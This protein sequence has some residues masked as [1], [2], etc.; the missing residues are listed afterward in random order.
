MSLIAWYPLNGNTEDYSG[1]NYHGTIL[2]SL[3]SSDGKIGPAYIFTNSDNGVSIPNNN[4]NYLRDFT[5]TAWINPVGN[6]QNYDG[7]I[8]SSGNW[9]S[10]H[11]S[12]GVKQDNSGF[13]CRNPYISS[14][15]AP[16]N[17]TLNKWHFV[18]YK[19]QNNKL[20]L[21]ANNTLVYSGTNDGYIPLVSDATNTTI[22]RETYGSGYFS[23]NG[24]IQDVRI[25]NHALTEKEIKELSK[26]KILH[27][28]FDDFQEPTDNIIYFQNP[29]IDNSYTPFVYTT[30]GTWPANHPDAITVYNID[31]TNISSYV[32]TGVTDWTNANHATWVFDSELQRPVVIMR[33]KSGTWQAKFM[34]LSSMSSLGLS[35][36][37]Q[38]VISWLQWTSDISKSANVGVY[39]P[40]TSGTYGFYDG[41]SNSQTTSYNT[42]PYTWQRVYAIFTVNSVRNMNAGSTLYMYGHFGP[43]GTLKI[44][45]VQFEKKNHVTPF[46]SKVRGGVIHDYSGLKHH[47]NLSLSTTPQWT[48]DSKIGAG[49]Y[50][51]QNS[52][53]TSSTNNHSTY[54][55]TYSFW[56]KINKPY[57]GNFHKIIEKTLV[58]SDR[59]PGVWLYP[60]STGLHLR[61]HLLDGTNAGPGDITDMEVGKWYHIVFSC[62]WDGTTTTLSR[63]V[64][65]QNYT[66]NTYSVAP[67]IGNAPLSV[68]ADSFSDYYLDDLRIYGTVLSEEEVLELY[69]QRMN[70]D[71]QGN[72]YTTQLKDYYSKYKDGIKP[73]SYNFH[74]YAKNYPTDSTS[75][76]AGVYLN[77]SLVYGY[78]RDWHISVWDPSIGDWASSINFYG[79]SSVSGSHARY[80]IYESTTR[81]AQQNAFVNTLLNLDPNYIV[82]IAGSHAPEYYSQEMKSV[83]L[84][85][86]A[87]DKLLSWTTRESYILI[88]KKNVGEGN[89]IK[90][91]LSNLDPADNNGYK[92]SVAYFSLSKEIT[93]FE[94]KKILVSSNFSE[95][96]I[97]DG[98]IAY[99]P[100]D[101]HV[102]D[103]SGSGN[104]GNLIGAS[105]TAGIKNQGLAFLS[106]GQ[107]VTISNISNNVLTLSCWHKWENNSTTWRTLFG[108]NSNIHHVIFEAN[109]QLSLW[110]GSQKVYGYTV[111]DSN[112][113][114]YVVII[115]SAANAILYVDGV[116]IGQTSTSLDLFTYPIQ[117]IG[118]WGGDSYPCGYMDEVRVYNRALTPQEIK[119]MYDIYKPNGPVF[120]ITKNNIYVRNEIK[121]GL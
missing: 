60:T 67:L 95:A 23:F 93:K 104:H 43:R 52:S 62:D 27:Y 48:S 50:L 110:D 103:Y 90:E 77:S 20:F 78:S 98:L 13:S 65:G 113:H 97:A 16:H 70:L 99:Y 19:R 58:N 118:N 96:G 2:G 45:D 9:N 116:Y 68:I 105:Y 28:S 4:F 84:N 24:K 112:W 54:T 26:A 8:I 36:G 64:N 120:K 38:Y 56:I 101:S 35:A 41:L 12:F 109:G 39:G 22:G 25:Y 72:L 57:D 115:T 108:N 37:S 53:F 21:Y 91:V 11:W 81:T 55:Y 66:F 80:D 102:K 30:S 31:G 7:T 69:Q 14:T 73:D 88:G 111:T 40:N 61:H 6:H 1:N 119:I 89:A 94:N 33:D 32:N 29:R 18:V 117:V 107:K 3:S 47:A 114:N 79:A 42:L 100:F 74:I 44:A 83:M 71:N 46:T 34:D 121:E 17:F 75:P 5:M 49:A 15:I 76:Q 82:I 51:M 85:Y 86:G 59:S 63:W 10:Q 87:T 92:W 106:N